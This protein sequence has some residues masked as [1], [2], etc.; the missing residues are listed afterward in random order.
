[1]DN[2]HC[3]F[4][5]IIAG[6]MNSYRIY[7]D[8]DFLAILDINPVSKGHTLL[9]P[10]KHFSVMPQIPAE[11]IGRMGIVTKKISNNMLKMLG[12]KATTIYI[13]NGSA[14]GQMAPHFM[15]HIIPN[16]GDKEPIIKEPEKELDQKEFQKQTAK[17]R[18]LLFSP[19]MATAGMQPQN[20][21]KENMENE[22]INPNNKNLLTPKK[23]DYP[24]QTKKDGKFA[25]PKR[26]KVS[27]SKNSEEPEQKENKESKTIDF[28][29]LG[30]MFK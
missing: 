23:Q 30:E 25:F 7:E 10:K 12:A 5:K 29:K 26:E 28:D 22:N 21:Q 20:K 18:T 1:M 24:R 6:E 27:S 9:L 16:Y 19:Q 8:N 11:V 2:N 3:I 4:C 13:A 17:I 14:A 15:V